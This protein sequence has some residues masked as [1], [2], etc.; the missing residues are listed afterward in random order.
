MENNSIVAENANYKL[1][2]NS[3][4]FKESF[5]G[6]YGHESITKDLIKNG[7]INHAIKIAILDNTSLKETD[8]FPLDK[9]GKKILLGKTEIKQLFDK[10]S[11]AVQANILDA[12]D[13]IVGS[14]VLPNFLTSTGYVKDKIKNYKKS[15][16]KVKKTSGKKSDIN[17]K[18][19]NPEILT[20][21][22]KLLDKNG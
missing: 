21:L 9:K 20:L 16:K 10:Q 5:S 12:F 8:V 18:D 13:D 4:S 17:L 2:E 3:K 14:K 1:S 11:K 6:R 19:I 22:S 7:S 15:G